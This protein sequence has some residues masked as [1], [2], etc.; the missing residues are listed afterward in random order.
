MSTG[1]AAMDATGARPVFAI[2]ARSLAVSPAAGAPPVLRDVSLGVR[3]GGRAALAGANGA[4][5]STLLRVFAGL[6]PPAAGGAFVE[7]APARAGNP[8]VAWLAQRPAVEW[9]FP[10]TVRQA[11]LAGRHIRLGWFRRPAPAD[12]AKADEALRR[13][14]LEAFAERPLDALSG[15]QQQRLLAAR[16]LCQE[17]SVLLLDEPFAALDAASV[18]ILADFIEEAPRHGLTVL[19]ATHEIAG[20]RRCFDTVFRIRDGL[21]FEEPDCG[22]CD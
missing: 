15:G 3:P 1:G 8:R 4:G 16:A 19:A 13:L 21:V 17:A 5:K 22:P 7:G 12:R 6:L 2:E 9:R 11:V 14:G 20:A 10:V 18:E